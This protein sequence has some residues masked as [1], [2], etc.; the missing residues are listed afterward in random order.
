M[1]RATPLLA[2]GSVLAHIFCCGL[3]VLANLLLFLFNAGTVG[4]HFPG[5]EKFHTWIHAHEIWILLFS[6]A[7]LVIGIGSIM[8]NKHR[9]CSHTCEHGHRNHFDIYLLI[10]AVTAFGLNALIFLFEHMG[11]TS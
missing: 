11:S 4:A 1:P 7:M 8:W 3:P 9:S 6:F 5:F 2:F 10:F